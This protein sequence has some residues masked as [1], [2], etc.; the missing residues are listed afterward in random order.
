MLPTSKSRSPS[1]YTRNGSATRVVLARIWIIPSRVL[2]IDKA[3][4]AS[5]EAA[6]DVPSPPETTRGTEAASALEAV[7][8]TRPAPQL[9]TDASFPRRTRSLPPGAVGDPADP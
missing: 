3:A 1:K 2:P 6:A 4:L 8:E 5:D 9:T 7:S